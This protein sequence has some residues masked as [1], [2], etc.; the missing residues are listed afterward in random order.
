[1]AYLM[2]KQRIITALIL[3]IVVYALAVSEPNADKRLAK[4][5][6]AIVAGQLAKVDEAAQKKLTAIL[7][8]LAAST[9]AKISVSV[10]APISKDRLDLIVTTPEFKDITHTGHG[11]AIY[12]PSL[13]VIFIDKYL[14]APIDMLH[15]GETG[16]FV[17]T[18]LALTELDFVE[19]YLTF[20]IAH[21]LGHRHEGRKGGAFFS[22]DWLNLSDNDVAMEMQADK[23]AVQLIFN[24]HL[25]GT[26]PEFI[27]ENTL[28]FSGL[29]GDTA[30]TLAAGQVFSG[31]VGM[32]LLMQFG[33]GP[34]SPFF[35]DDAHP[36]FL[37]RALAAV[38]KSLGNAG[39][40]IKAQA[41]LISE[42]VK[43]TKALQR[44]DTREIM[45][46][47][48]VARIEWRAGHL[49]I[50][51]VATQFGQASAEPLREAL[52]QL[53]EKRE[54]VSF[55]LQA[56]G[57]T[58]DTNAYTGY[59]LN[60]LLKAGN[61]DIGLPAEEWWKSEMAAY[62]TP[63]VKKSAGFHYDDNVQRWS[64]QDSG[65]I[66]QITEI[67]LRQA[68]EKIYGVPISKIGI[69]Y[70]FS[71]DIFFPVL[72][73]VNNENNTHELKFLRLHAATAQVNGSS[74]R[75]KPQRG[76][77]KLD[78][79]A[80]LGEGWFALAEVSTE[81]QGEYLLFYWLLADGDIKLLG[82][83]PTF[84]NF[85]GDGGDKSYGRDL[86]ASS[87]FFQHLSTH[88]LLVW[89]DTGS[90]WRVASSGVDVAFNPGNKALQFTNLDNE[91][92]LI[93]ISNARKGYLVDYSTY[94][95]N[96]N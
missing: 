80:P 62:R 58:T 86:D 89:S 76:W 46:P 27:K 54:G 34:Y 78:T 44:W 20:I 71:K 25:A 69:P 73:V 4:I 88:K 37:S 14:I 94:K 51:T 47:G 72:A 22:I 83:M 64:W 13:D 23:F 93:W 57:V 11:N 92:A 49:W 2:S 53:E 36:D 70:K 65:K 84:F 17:Q 33:S 5:N 35:Y 52:Y 63:W 61:V 96:I 8:W 31:L 18:T 9:H 77:I 68:G 41:P 24:A 60:S 42:R 30:Q 28:N 6:A 50:G 48:P 32:S 55:K 21:E 15:V 91:R 43:R 29:R 16:S 38:E 59:W 95:N 19:N 12:D 90:V 40:L 85:I 39:T 45:F 75:F 1:M 79:V 7:K 74:L 10:N 3:L 56:E 82:C 66:V 67:A 81:S 87:Y 26:A